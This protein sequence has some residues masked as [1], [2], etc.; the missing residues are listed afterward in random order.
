MATTLNVLFMALTSRASANNEIPIYCRLTLHNRQQR[1]MIGEKIPADLWDKVKQRA[2]G[3]SPKA[4]AVNARIV[5]LTQS[6]HVAEASLIK[7]GEAF[8]VEDIIAKALG[9]E[10]AAC[11]T[12]MQLYEYRFK[13]MKSLQGKDY[14]NST[15]VK[16]LQ[17]ANAVR[18]FIREHY[19]M[20]DIGL[21]KV[22]M[23]FL[24]SLEVYLKTIKSMKLISVN[25][26]IQK[27]KSVVSMAVNFGWI[28]GNPFPGH[29]FKHDKINVMFLTRD[30]LELLET[31]HI[32]QGRLRKVRDIFLFS[33]YTGLHYSDAMYLTDENI[34]TDESGTRWIRY[35]RIKTKKEIHIPL[36]SKADELIKHFKNEDNSLTYLLPRISN[37]KINSYLKEVSDIVGLKIPLTH[38][39]AR[40]TFGSILLY[41]NVPMKV[42]SELMGHS[43]VIVTEKHYAQIE[44]KKLK[45]SMAQVDKDMER[46]KEDIKP[47]VPLI[48]FSKDL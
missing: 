17:L 32:A 39:I 15:V 30:E 35:I 40:K 21:S 22:D 10:K 6:I 43:T 19:G 26:V 12:L 8:E 25:K 36:L 47:I 20:D 27:L 34:I 23:Q 33:V 24:Q 41:Y 37:Q 9:K 29:K 3:R 38:K 4:N 45:L 11:R 14:T 46:V 16:F 48:S 1:F 2:K 5:Q 31:A 13:Q 42:V 7:Q 18:S 28:A 44:R